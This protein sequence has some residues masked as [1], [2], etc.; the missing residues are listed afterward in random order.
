MR[1]LV[2]EDRVGQSGPSSAHYESA[3]NVWTSGSSSAVPLGK[4]RTGLV[5]PLRQPIVLVDIDG[6]SI[7]L[8]GAL[9]DRSDVGDPWAAA[10][11]AVVETVAVPLDRPVWALVT[12]P[13]GTT[14]VAVHPDGSISHLDSAEPS[15]H[16]P[17]VVDVAEPDPEP[18]DVE[19]ASAQDATAAFLARNERTHDELAAF[20]ARSARMQVQ[21]N[22]RPHPPERSHRGPGRPHPVARRLTPVLGVAA[23]VTV[24]LT[25]ALLITSGDEL[26]QRGDEPSAESAYVKDVLPAAHRVQLRDRFPRDLV[27][28]V[29]PQEESVTIRIASSLLPVRARIVLSPVDGERVERIVTLRSAT[30]R[31]EVDGLTPGLV[32]WAIRVVGARPVTGSVRVPEAP[33]EKPTTTAPDTSTPQTPEEPTTTEPSE[34]LTP[35]DPDEPTGPIDPD[36][37]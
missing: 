16:L 29:I 7:T 27:A 11:R 18:V 2:R 32:D 10:I 37:L 1:G 34:T 15:L 21:T 30:T 4:G 26:P 17:P 35:V 9:V 36:D 19:P 22:R 28:R 20:L 12:E 14:K 6:D 13:G 23:L 25:A 8:N 24:A 5:E 3:R 31:L 33:T